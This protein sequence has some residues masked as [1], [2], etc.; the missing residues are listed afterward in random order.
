MKN[1]ILNKNYPLIFKIKK[2]Y[3]LLLLRVG[4][5]NNTKSI[6]QFRQTKYGLFINKM[7]IKIINYATCSR[8]W[9]NTWQGL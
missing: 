5:I 7:K 4:V 1:T 3:K 2:N 9:R 8:C 6:T